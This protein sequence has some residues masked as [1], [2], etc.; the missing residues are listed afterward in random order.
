VFSGP[1]THKEPVEPQGGIEPPI[2]A[3]PRRRCEANWPSTNWLISMLRLTTDSG[4]SPHDTFTSWASIWRSTT[5]A[6]FVRESGA[7]AT[8]HRVPDQ[9]YPLLEPG[10]VA[11]WMRRCSRKDPFLFGR[12]TYLTAGGFRL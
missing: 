4:L 9:H 6:V 10:N 7:E 3:L 12:S 2:C 1:L 5:F 8:S 11:N